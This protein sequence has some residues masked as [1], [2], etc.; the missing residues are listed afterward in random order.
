MQRLSVFDPMRR[1]QSSPSPGASICMERHLYD[2]R[3]DPN[4]IVNRAGRSDMREISAKLRERIVARIVENGETKPRLRRPDGTRS[5][6]P[7]AGRCAAPVRFQTRFL[8]HTRN[9]HGACARHALP[10]G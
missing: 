3:S 6:L 10:F 9:H 1:T 5:A 2:P 7:D 8:P 4:E